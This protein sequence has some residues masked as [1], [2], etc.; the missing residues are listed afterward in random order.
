MMV[1]TNWFKRGEFFY[2]SIKL[3]VAKFGTISGH[4]TGLTFY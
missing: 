3:I 4:E 2:C 1:V